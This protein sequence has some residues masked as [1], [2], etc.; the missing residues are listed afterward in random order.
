V[1]KQKEFKVVSVLVDMGSTTPTAVAEFSEDI[2]FVSE[3]SGEEAR[4]IFE[5]I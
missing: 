2:K 3:L 4:E 5:V 1:K